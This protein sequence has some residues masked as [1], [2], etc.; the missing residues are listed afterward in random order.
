MGETYAAESRV[1]GRAEGVCGGNQSREACAVGCE[2]ALNRRLWLLV[3]FFI[4]S[5]IEC[6][7]LFLLMR[8]PIS[9]LLCT[10]NSG[11][12][13]SAEPTAAISLTARMSTPISRK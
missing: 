4:R 11:P 13:T 3:V 6:F 8:A 10:S 7:P 5:F 9:L 1:V 12:T 2:L